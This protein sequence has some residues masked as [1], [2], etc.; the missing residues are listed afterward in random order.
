MK[1]LTFISGA[2][3]AG[4]TY[5]A[6]SMQSEIG[7]GNCSVLGLDSY[8]KTRQERSALGVYH[9]YDTRSYDTKQLKADLFTLINRQEEI[10]VSEYVHGGGS[11][12]RKVIMPTDHIIVEGVVA[13]YDEVI[14]PY[15]NLAHT[16]FIKISDSMI[17]NVKVGADVQRGLLSKYSIDDIMKT[18]NYYV[19]G[20]IEHCKDMSI[21]NAKQVINK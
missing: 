2:S 15:R 13:L 4:K 10:E 21:K 17:F 8:L 18:A 1:Q 14:E 6:K 5:L 9:G 19:A 16:I 12:G 3:G 7:L 11:S 20:Y